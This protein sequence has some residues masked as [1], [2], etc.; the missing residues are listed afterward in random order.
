MLTVTDDVH[1][2]L[3]IIYAMYEYEYMSKLMNY[4]VMK[5]DAVCIFC[6]HQ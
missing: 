3:Y 6:I 5:Y 2:P 4:E 1:M